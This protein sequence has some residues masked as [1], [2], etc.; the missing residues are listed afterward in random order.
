MPKHK[1]ALV[2][3]ARWEEMHIHEWLAYHRSIGFDHVYLYSNDDDPRALRRL[4]TPYLHGSDPFVTFRHWPVVGEQ[5]EIY[6]H[7]LATFKHETEWFSFLDIDEYFVLKGLNDIFPFMLDYENHVDCLYFNWVIF[8][9]SGK[10]RRDDAPTLTS[11]LRRGATADIHTKMICRSAL[12]DADA[13]RHGLRTGRG[14]YWHFMDNYLLP[15]VR[16]RDVL[17]MPTNGYSA[18]FPGSAEP[19]VNRAGFSESVLNKGYIAHYQFRSEED[20]IRRWRRRGFANIE[21]MRA[22][23]ETGEHKKILAKNNIVYDTYLAEYWYRYTAPALRF[24]ARPPDGSPPYENVALNKPSFQSSILHAQP[25]EPESARVT[26]AGNNGLRTG[27]YGFHTNHEIR[28]WWMVDLL[29]LHRIVEIHIYNRQGDPAVVARANEL[30]VLASADGTAWR[31]LLSRDGAAPFGLD[32]APLIIEAQ[33]DGPYRFVLLR[34]RSA[35][36]LHLDEVEIFGFPTG[37]DVP[38]ALDFGGPVPPD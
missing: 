3:T 6:L 15:N 12:I 32:G 35:S 30:D 14:A 17:L 27:T 20:F 9:N 36:C 10:V 26:G 19:F 34:L 5:R 21:M 31:T 38:F 2:A 18:A 4:V 23:Y 37:G 8:G 33:P 1:F 16:C 24:A 25:G 13:V 29:A 28:P 7:F 11:Y 22:L